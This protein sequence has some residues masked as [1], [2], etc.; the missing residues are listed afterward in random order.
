[1]KL[2]GKSTSE[3]I[4]SLNE[5]CTLEQGAFDAI[6]KSSMEKETLVESALKAYQ[7]TYGAG[8]EAMGAIGTQMLSE[9]VAI[10]RQIMMNNL[11]GEENL[12]NET[13]NIAMLTTTLAT[14]CRRPMESHMHR[15]FDTQAVQTPVVTIESYFDTLTNADNQVVDAFNAFN[16]GAFLDTI[17]ES[18]EV[19][20]NGLAPSRTQRDLLVG[21]D[22]SIHRIDKDARISGIEYYNAGAK[23]EASKIRY[24]RGSV[25][26][27][28][29]KTGICEVVFE[30]TVGGSTIDVRIDAKINFAT[31]MLE[32]LNAD[33]VKGSGDTGVSLVFFDLHLAF[34]AHTSAITLG[35]RNN[36]ISLPMPTAPH[37]EVSET[38]ETLNDISKGE[39]SLK[40]KDFVANLTDKMTVYSAAKEDLTLFKLLEKPENH[41]YEM[42]YD[43]DSPS[44]YAAGSPFEWIKLNFINLC[45]L[46]CTMMKQEYHV[47]N[48]V[49]KIAVSPIML[50]VIDNGY[51]MDDG[52]AQGNGVLNYSV[53]A[54]TAANTM[55][56]VS[57]ERYDAHGQINMIL[58]GEETAVVK[59]FCYYKYQSFLT[60]ALQSSKNN[61]RKAIVFSERNLPTVL[62]PVGAKISIANMPHKASTGNKI[63]RVI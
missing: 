16:D 41:Q 20:T 42:N 54:K 51:K 49:F 59:T 38:L 46:T 21:H 9:D 35:G 57:S 63:V 27:F 4:Q 19:G 55:V 62:E 3:F 29:S 17:V 39:S 18:L 30:V 32:Y 5:Q 44:T 56:F 1:M 31:G 8:F 45:D 6:K 22:K 26:Y 24:K 33:S 40:G 15:I 48:A 12:L 34:D 14:T 52:E 11:A 13:T 50:R 28:D 53:S 23:L 36:F 2:Q 37:F 7:E 60:D 25:P 10:A 58:N 61:A 47:K 43:Y